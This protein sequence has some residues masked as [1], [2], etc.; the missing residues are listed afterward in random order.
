MPVLA[1][2]QARARQLVVH[3][4]FSKASTSGWAPASSSEL[5]QQNSLE[6]G[7]SCSDRTFECPS[8]LFVGE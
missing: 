5:P 7:V 3:T 6:G 1:R 8:S 2:L 4:A